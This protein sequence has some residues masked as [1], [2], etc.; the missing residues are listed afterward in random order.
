MHKPTWYRSAALKRLAL[1]A[2]GLGSAAALVAAGSFALFTSQATAQ[3]DTFAAGTVIL[4]SMSPNNNCTPTGIDLTNLE[5]GD[6]GTC[7]YVLNYKGSLNAWVNLSVGATTSSIAKVTPPGSLSSMGGEYLLGDQSSDMP[8]ALQVSLSDSNGN[9]NQTPLPIACPNNDTSGTAQSDVNCG[10]GLVLLKGATTCTG[11]A[12]ECNAAPTGSWAPNSSDTVT[13]NWSL[14]LQTNNPYQ[15]SDATISLVGQ[16]VQASNN[17]LNGAC[18]TFGAPVISNVTFT[19]VTSDP[20]NLSGTDMGITVTGCGF[21]VEPTPQ[22]NADLTNAFSF[23]DQTQTDGGASPGGWAA[24]CS[25]MPAGV[26]G[27]CTPTGGANVVGLNYQSWT[28]SQ[29]V[30]NGFGSGYNQADYGYHGWIVQPGDAV[31]I[32]VMNPVT[33][34]Y[35]IWHGTL[36]NN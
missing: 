30:I 36:P 33:L 20:S 13:L 12:A 17:P 35:A 14:P 2:G 4:T 18:E 27:Y 8:D 24:G 23:S 19:G 29:I 5:P 3:T 1:L 11:T 10:S 9:L 7:T 25:S 26:T 31:T 22:P 34:Q 28:G 32:I 15:G 16:A 6:S 21:G